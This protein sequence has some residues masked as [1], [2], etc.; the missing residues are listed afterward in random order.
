[1]PRQVST[2]PGKIRQRIRTSAADLDRD[3]TLLYGKTVDEW[4]F[5]ELCRGR[6][7]APDGKFHGPRPSA[8]DDMVRGQIYKRLQVIT[9]NEMSR[10]TGDAITTI[11]EIM[12][13]KETDENGKYL[14]P[15]S[16]RLDAARYLL[17]QL[18]GK[19][20]A[21]VEVTGA[22][23]LQH[24][25][26]AIMVNPDGRDAHPVIEGSSVTDDEEDTDEDG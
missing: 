22:L 23:D 16:V 15:S 19:A 14:T 25:L 11:I 5:E 1:M 9:R 4:D 3:V 21:K 24:I 7:R 6:P 12:Q 17:D 13:D 10:H 26:A 8:L 18:I 20:T 2:K